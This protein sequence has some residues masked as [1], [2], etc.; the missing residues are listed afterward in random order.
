[1]DVK[2]MNITATVLFVACGL[3]LA[4]ALGWW[5][6]R[7]PLFA[8]GGITVQG[9]VTHNSVATL[10]ANVAPQLAGN[11]FTVDLKQRAR[12]LRGRALGAAG[13]GAARSSRT[14]CACAAGAP[15]EAFWGA[16]AESHL[17]NTFG[18]VF[19]ANV[20][21]RRTGRPAAPGGPGR[22]AA[23]CWRCTAR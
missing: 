19:E 16:E 12:S 11:F 18:E 9:D 20:R 23:R 3:L 8:I 21:R 7:H 6:L 2:L 1:V 4:A 15:A 5:A 13:G 22:Q 10:R 14:G 17:V